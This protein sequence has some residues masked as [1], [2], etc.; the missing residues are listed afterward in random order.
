MSGDKR[1]RTGCRGCGQKARCYSLELLWHVSKERSGVRRPHHD[2]DDQELDGGWW[3]WSNQW[4][5][6]PCCA[7]AE[8]AIGEGGYVPSKNPMV[9]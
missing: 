4:L 6:P 7:A 8:D 9:A 2:V 3:L 1:K 5:C